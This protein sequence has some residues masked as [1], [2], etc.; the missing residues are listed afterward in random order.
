MA[1][2]GGRWETKGLAG[3]ELDF[4]CVLNTVQ[5]PSPFQTKGLQL[6]LSTEI[7]SQG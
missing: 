1:G 3:K 7:Q 5:V 2:V 4:S 6:E